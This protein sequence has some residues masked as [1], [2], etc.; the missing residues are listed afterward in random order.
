MAT[1]AT[2]VPTALGSIV[3]PN[4]KKNTDPNASR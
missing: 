3:R 2:T 1:G 4:A